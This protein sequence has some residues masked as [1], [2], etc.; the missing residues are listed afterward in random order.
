MDNE[1]WVILLPITLLPVFF[2]MGW[3]AARIDMKTVLKQAK[4]VMAFTPFVSETLLDVCDVLLPIAPFTETSGSFINM[5]G[6]L[7]SFHGVVQGFGDSRPL[8]KVLRVLG[9]LFDLKG[10]EYHDTAAILKD[11]LD[12]ESLP[13]K[14]NNR[15]ASTQK[16][17]QTTS[18]RNHQRNSN[19][20]RRNQSTRY[21]RS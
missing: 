2:A 21:W 18:N 7:Q 15:A 13:S 11:A 19:E 3:F 12:A 6:R 14:L 20:Y 5:E 16:D 4:S 8:W 10:F 17:F 9:N 1:L